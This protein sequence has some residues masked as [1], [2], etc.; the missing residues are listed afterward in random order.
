MLALL[1][2]ILSL[3][4][5]LRP[6]G[7]TPVARASSP[8]VTSVDFSSTTTPPTVTVNGS[9][10]GTEPTPSTCPN[11]D[12]TALGYSGHNYGADPS[13]SASNPSPLAFFDTHALQGD[14]PWSGGVDGN[15]VGLLI[16]AYGDSGPVSF[17]FGDG[18]NWY[19]AGNNGD[20][21]LSQGDSFTVYVA[22][23]R[24]SRHRGLQHA[25]EL[26]VSFPHLDLH[27]D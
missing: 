18:Y 23:A 2:L 27:A 16:A 11:C 5:S 1:C 24:C 14:S 25:G 22:G 8:V 10:F 20:Y 17:S 6:T 26:C 19:I 13:T 12:A 3:V 15:H 4:A 21:L 7:T 9:G